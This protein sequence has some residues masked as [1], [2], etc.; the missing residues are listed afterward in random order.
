M[1]AQGALTVRSCR[2]RIVSSSEGDEVGVTLRIHDAATSLL[3]GFFEKTSMIHE[4][5]LVAI[6]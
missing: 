1:S 3:K 4:D 5:L 6:A 2:Y